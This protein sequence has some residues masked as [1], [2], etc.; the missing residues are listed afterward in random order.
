MSKSST[1]NGSNDT[2]P[3]LLMSPKGI[4]ADGQ[5]ASPKDCSIGGIPSY[6]T[7]ENYRNPTCGICDRSMYLLAQVYAPLDGLERTL[8]VFGC[9]QGEC[10]NKFGSFKCIR[11]QYEVNEELLEEKMEALKEEPVKVSLC[12]D[13]NSW[14]DEDSWGDNDF[15]DDNE[16][17]DTTDDFEAIL[18][19]NEQKLEK[20]QL[21][22]N[23]GKNTTE[24]STFLQSCNMQ[25]KQYLGLVDDKAA[26]LPRRLLELHDEPFYRID[27]EDDD[28]V[29][30]RSSSDDKTIDK[31]NKYLREEEDSSIQALISQSIEKRTNRS[32]SSCDQASNG[33]QDERLPKSMSSFLDFTERIKFSP[34]QVIRYAYGGEP[35]LSA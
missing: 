12:F 4:D 21:S 8:Y 10:S 33:E 30:T 34:D 32:T 25:K 24:N 11:D 20:C 35:L 17:N 19:A 18:R 22:S 15:D 31:L 14:G 28:Q 13:D 6:F 7:L 2:E 3:V 23:K 5:K 27:E 9:N 26:F 29:G 16:G 1:K